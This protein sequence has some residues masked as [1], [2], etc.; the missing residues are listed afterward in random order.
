MLASA[1]RLLLVL[2]LAATASACAEPPPRPLLWKVGDGDNHLYLL[3]SFHLLKESDYPLDPATDLAFED[4]ERL[5]F[6]LPPDAMADPA[7]TR[8]MIQAA[9][10]TDGS[11]LRDELPEAAWE[12]LQAHAQRR[13]L[14]LEPMQNLEAWYVGLM[15]SLSEMQ[16]QGMLPEH[17]LDKHFARRAAAAGKPAEGLET[18]AE[19]IALFDDMDPELQVRSLERTLEEIEDLRGRVER[20]HGLWRDGDADGL[21]AMT[22]AE[23]KAEQP[24]LY[25][26]V[27]TERN[28]AW[29]PRLKAMLDGSTDQDVLVV[30]G[31]LHLLGEDGLVALLEAEGYTVERL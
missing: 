26:R 1:V 11:R 22:G 13:R 21:Y 25:A 20:M 8:L 4:A 12:R 24:E 19:Q 3:G 5:V 7:T 29:L 28:R 10:R 15:V 27:N 6:E 9:Q 2:F 31:A 16:A 23:M 18:V 14:P 17:G 30:V